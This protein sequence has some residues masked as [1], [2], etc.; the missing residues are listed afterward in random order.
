MKNRSYLPIFI[1][2]LLVASSLRA[3]DTFDDKRHEKGTTAKTGSIKKFNPLKLAAQKKR[4]S[5]PG[6]SNFQMPSVFNTS[7][8]PSKYEH[9]VLGRSESG[10]PLFIQ[11]KA[12]KEVATLAS[13]QAPEQ[14]ANDYL[15]DVKQLIQIE[16]PGAEFVEIANTTDALGQ[17]HLKM[18]QVFKGIKVYGGEV[19]LHFDKSNKVSAMNGR[20]KPTPRIESTIPKLSAQDA[21][22]RVENDLGVSFPAKAEKTN[23][24]FADADYEEEL[25]IY[26]FEGKNV[27]ARHLTVHPN[28]KDRWEYFIDAQNGRILNK[29]YHTCTLY[30]EYEKEGHGK[31]P[32]ASPPS[33]TS[34]KDLNGVTRQLDTY[35]V[36][37]KNYMINTSKSMF[38]AGQSKIP[39]NPVGAIMTLDLKNKAPGEDVTIYHVTSTS[40]S[41]NDP[42]AVSAHYNADVSYDYFENKFNRNSINGQGGTIISIINVAADDGGG[43]DNAFWNGKAIFYGNGKSAFSP[44]AGA[45]DVGGHE[46]SHGVIEAT[47]NL[48]Y[49]YQSG[50][51]NESFADIFGTMIDR[52]DWLLGEDIVNRQYF[53]SG[54]MRNMQ[55]PNNGVSEGQRGWQPK[56]MTEYYSGEQDNGGVHINSGIVNRAYYL[57]ATDMGKDKAEQIYYRALVTYLTASSQFVDLR[58]AIVQSAIDLHGE[59]SAEVKAVETAFDTVGITAG[60]STDTENDI[61]L[62][63]GDEFILSVDIRDT[64]P[65]TIYASDTEAT[66]YYPLTTTGVHR[67]PSVSD[68][69]SFAIFVTEDRTVNAITLDVN[70]PEESVISEDPVWA[71][72]SLSKDGTKL[73]SVL[74]DESNIIYVSDLVTG[75]FKEFELYNPTS[76]D[77][78]TTGEVLYP[79]ALEWDYTGQYLIYDALN[80]LNNANGNDIEYWDVGALH[81]WDNQGNAFAD[82]RIQKIFTNLPEG[83]SIGNPSFSKTSGNILAFDYF[84]E[85][86]DEYSII[87]VNI[88]TGDIKTVYNNNKLGFPNFSK[89]DDKLIFDTYNGSDEDIMSIDLAAD[90]MTPV[91]SVAELIPNGKWGIWYTVG[92]RST[93]SSEKEITDFRFNVTSPPTVGSINGNEISMPLPA[94]INPGNLVAI[95]ATSARATVSVSGVPQQSGATYNDFTDPVVYT[96]MAEDGSTKDFTV[97]LMANDPNDTD[98]DGVP[99]ADD[100]CPNTPLG[101][102]VDVT[103]C[104]VFSLPSTNFTVSAKGESCMDSHNGSIDISANSSHNYIATLAGN[105]VS[106]T[107]S[108]TSSV[109]FS[110][111]KSGSYSVCITVQ[112]QAGF[113]RCFDLGVTEPEALSVSSK[114]NLRASSVSLNLSG[115]EEYIISLDNETVVTQ[116]SQITLPLRTSTAKLTVETNKGCQGTYKEDLVLH[117]EVIVYPNPVESGDIS[118][119]LGKSYGHTIPVQLNA[120]DGRTILQKSIAPHTNT[121]T[122]DAES[123]TAGVYILSVQI[124]EETKT[125]KIVKQ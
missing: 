72:V 52:D 61:P 5:L 107:Q 117:E 16:N 88:E 101:T 108:F 80:R 71:A 6:R 123:L 28:I 115:A 31:A 30:H 21:L 37:G 94:N 7:S 75:E 49:S 2:A 64:D 125:Y 33:N 11:S 24:I 70:A 86:E 103:G 122:L 54:A 77:G 118:V 59:N 99:N 36:D 121:I 73:A 102:T 15:A 89:T 55:D 82:G 116:E 114:V 1:L 97:R 78:I 12:G 85:I 51:I 66:V 100:L 87:T 84:N 32:L 57:I 68:D 124:N 22:Q 34:G 67:K 45:L 112:G 26:P 3:Q 47:A 105:G 120:F 74:N 43:Y 104:E 62:A 13:K 46:M 18:Q 92:S 56:D 48:E 19:I 109:S 8:G 39:D 50:A 90:K 83:V 14:V 38:N 91:G 58:I 81:V 29:I 40:N 113:E 44:L 20:N 111:L 23:S 10:M 95:F 35:S 9:R 79:D 41:W 25:L 65:N 60:T 17:K 96:V 4:Q 93:L 76:A 53:T 119:V 42:A 69:G 110:N 106:E 98:N 63:E 27:L